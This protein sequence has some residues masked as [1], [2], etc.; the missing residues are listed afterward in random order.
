MRDRIELQSMLE[1]LLGN[2]NV[3]YNPPESVKMKYPAI[4]YSVNEIEK[5]T[6]DDTAYLFEKSY[7]IIVIDSKSDNEIIEKLMR[8]PYCSHNS[9]YIADNLNH[10]VFTLYW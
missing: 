5:K 4:R 2:K 6:A 3:Y 1:E 9:Y 8:L 7:K 10:D